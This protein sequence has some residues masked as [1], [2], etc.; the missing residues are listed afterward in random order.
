MSRFTSLC[1][2]AQALRGKAARR[3][4]RS[5]RFRFQAGVERVEE[6][7]LMSVMTI[8]ITNYPV[9][10]P[11]VIVQPIVAVPPMGQAP[12][13]APILQAPPGAASPAML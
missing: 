5:R 6:R 2:F 3:E 4:R 10:G 7:D 9:R 12:A 8:T 1:S 13:G 11:A